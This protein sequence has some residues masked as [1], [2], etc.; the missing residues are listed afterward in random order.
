MHL[1]HQFPIGTPRIMSYSP[2]RGLQDS[3]TPKWIRCRREGGEPLQP[4]DGDDRGVWEGGVADLPRP[5]RD[6]G[7]GAQ[8]C[9]LL[10]GPVA[11]PAGGA[12]G[13]YDLWAVQVY[14]VYLGLK[15]QCHHTSKLWVFSWS[16][17]LGL[18]R[19]CHEI[20]HWGFLSSVFLVFFKEI[21]EILFL[22][23]LS[24]VYLGLKEILFQHFQP[25]V[26]SSI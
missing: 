17:Y 10:P 2:H 6:T 3:S 21:R 1:N 7:A 11:S 5:R 4:P 23:F 8:P 15:G 12:G 24:L 19:K 20:F 26:L 9:G 13:L 25:R 18:S 16:V 14:V 22:R